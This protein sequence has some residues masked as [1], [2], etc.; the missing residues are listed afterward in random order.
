MLLGCVLRVVHS[1]AHGVDVCCMY[2]T[3]VTDLMWECMY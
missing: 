1:A 3:T 2:I